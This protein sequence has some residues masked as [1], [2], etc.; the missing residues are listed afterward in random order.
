MKQKLKLNTA[1]VTSNLFDKDRIQNLLLTNQLSKTII[2]IRT[3]NNANRGLAI[4]DC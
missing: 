1:L 3:D 4:L 2:A